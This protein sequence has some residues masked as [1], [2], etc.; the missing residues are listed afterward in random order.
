M[1]ATYTIANTR[2]TILTRFEAVDHRNNYP[3]AGV[4]N[5]VTESNG[6]AASQRE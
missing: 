6:T 5:G 4:S 2:C 3:R 1:T